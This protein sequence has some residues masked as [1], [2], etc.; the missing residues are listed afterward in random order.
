M[1]EF[2][3]DI[4]GMPIAD[5]LRLARAEMDKAADASFKRLRAELVRDGVR[6][7]SIRAQIEGEREAWRKR[8]EDAL[9]E[10]RY[11]L[12]SS[13]RHEIHIDTSGLIN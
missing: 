9:A 3:M 1:R 4:R 11:S 2:E 8:R 7:D 6:Q 13:R 5:V 12:I 10:L